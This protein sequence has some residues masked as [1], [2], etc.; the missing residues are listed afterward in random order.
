M[1]LHTTVQVR[2]MT[3]FIPNPSLLSEKLLLMSK[4][5]AHLS[6]ILYL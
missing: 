6:A 1:K 2:I 4:S 3:Y 5:K